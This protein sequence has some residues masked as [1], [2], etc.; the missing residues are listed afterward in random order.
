MKKELENKLFEKYPKLFRQKE[1]SMQET[2]MCWGLDCGAGW[3]WLLDNLCSCIQDYIDANNKTQAETVQV[4]EKFGGL[5]FYLDGA[6]TYIHGM[7]SLAETMSYS[8]CEVCG[9]TTEIIHT[10]GWIKTLCKSC[11]KKRKA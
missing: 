4:K 1:L 5:R 11:A 7:V 3:Y 2:C 9:A 6:D 8:T 10:K